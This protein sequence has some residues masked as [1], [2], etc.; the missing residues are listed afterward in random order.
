MYINPNS[1]PCQYMQG[2]YVHPD[3]PG[4]SVNCNG[5]VYSY[6]TNRFLKCYVN[7]QGYKIL[8]CFNKREIS[9]YVK[10]HRLV[11]FHFV[12]LPLEFNGNY[13][14]ATIDHIDC[15]KLNN[16]YTN[17]EWVTGEEN[18]KRAWRNGLCDDN[19]KPIV[20]LD[21]ETRMTYNFSSSA[22]AARFLNLGDDS[23]RSYFRNN[24]K[25]YVAN[26]YIPGYANDE[27]FIEKLND[28]DA[29]IK[30]A[31][32]N[33]K[34]RP[35]FIIDK[36]S[37]EIRKFLSGRE[38]ERELSLYENAISDYLNKNRTGY[39][40][41]RYIPIYADDP[42]FESKLNNIE[43]M[44]KEANCNSTPYVRSVVCTDLINN[45][46]NEYPSV[47]ECSRQTGIN[48]LTISYHLT[49]G[50]KNPIHGRW[51]VVYKN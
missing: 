40:A 36:N 39:I 26:R 16:H 6:H 1:I 51:I 43:A 27:E 8:T 47:T 21:K 28:I 15:N 32:S 20:I 17:L 24:R 46:I 29:M 44:I 2:F 41:G 35:V 10:V 34:R 12:P 49:H 38:A 23:I 37:P 50:S 5:E 13:D 4:Y 25:G 33:M 45:T 18:L 9:K 30:E 11:A 3:Y 48:R 19:L 31:D 42:F 7:H 22:E 14:L